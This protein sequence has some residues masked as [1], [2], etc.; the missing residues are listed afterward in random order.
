MNATDIFGIIFVLFVFAGSA[1]VSFYMYVQFSH[2]L[3]RDFVGIWI[4]RTLIVLGM[5]IAFMMIF[6]LPID[7]LSTYEM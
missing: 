2:P 4:V 1:F 7:Y 5:T 6:I 3:D